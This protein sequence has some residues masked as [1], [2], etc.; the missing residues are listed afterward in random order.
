VIQ[1]LKIET[2]PAADQDLLLAKVE[3]LANNR[4]ATALP[5]LL[6]DEQFARIESMRHAGTPEFEI[7]AWAEAQLPDYPKMMQAMILDIA[8]ELSAHTS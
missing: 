8:D 2:A 1:A 6:T 4:F 5:E 7:M 3:L